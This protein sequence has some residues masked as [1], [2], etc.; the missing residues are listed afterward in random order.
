MRIPKNILKTLTWRLTASSTSLVIV[1]LLSGEFKI[2]GSF[3]IIE[4]ISK[5]VIYYLHESVWDK[6]KIEE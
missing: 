6:V 5:T 1:Y 4:A 2:A 3:A